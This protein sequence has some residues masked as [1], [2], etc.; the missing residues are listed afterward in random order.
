MSDE[1]LSEIKNTG[2][3]EGHAAYLHALEVTVTCAVANGGNVGGTATC[4]AGKYVAEGAIEKG[5][6]YLAKKI[7]RTLDKK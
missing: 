4:I 7:K 3:S 6:D 2:V 5:I 1:K